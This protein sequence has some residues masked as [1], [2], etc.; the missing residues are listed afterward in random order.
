MPRKAQ[1][2]T[3]KEKK[4]LDQLTAYPKTTH[5]IA[6]DANIDS[7]NASQYLIKLWK[8]GLAIMT[9]DRTRCWRAA[10]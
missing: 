10:K 6:Q 8:K 7:S 1:S 4:L 2:L 9:G 3:P 5:E